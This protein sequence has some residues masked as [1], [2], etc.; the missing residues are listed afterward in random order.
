ML[1]GSSTA[2]GFYDFGAVA[3]IKSAKVSRNSQNAQTRFNEGYALMTSVF[4]MNFPLVSSKDRI[5]L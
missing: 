5:T 3:T 1:I 2:D 4:D